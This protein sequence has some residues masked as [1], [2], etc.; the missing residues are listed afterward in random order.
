MKKINLFRK[1]KYLFLKIARAR[2]SINEIALGVGIGIFIGVFPTFGI[3]P[4]M[5]LLLY[6]FLPFNIVAALSSILISN[7]FTSPF[8]F[9]LIFQTGS[10]ILGSNV[11]FDIDNWK[12]NLKD[13]G[14]IMLWGSLVVSGTLGVLAYFISKFVLTKIRREKELK[15]SDSYRIQK[16]KL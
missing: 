1:A 8:F 11:D 5:I 7:P 12:E 10:V 9:V 14:I 13:T 16:K 6:R 3:G 4:L 15:Q 2:G